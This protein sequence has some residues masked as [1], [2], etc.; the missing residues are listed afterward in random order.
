MTRPS[1]LVVDDE[2]VMREL[3]AELLGGAGYDVRLAP[4]GLEGLG[5]IEQ[6]KPD[7]IIADINMPT[8]DGLAMTED[9]RL[10]G[11]TRN[12]P[13]ILITASAVAQKRA[14]GLPLDVKHCVTKPF[15]NDDLLAMVD[16]VLQQSSS[17]HAT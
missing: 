12:L 2:Q 13:I 17:S 15:S 14:E 11:E 8:L 10:Y 6:Q 7:L 16:H 4:D 1:I 9:L 5:L 3:L